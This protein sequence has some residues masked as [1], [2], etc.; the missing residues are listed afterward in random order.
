MSMGFDF[1]MIA[2]LLLSHCGVSVFG[3]RAFF[4]G[5]FQL[6]FFVTAASAVSCDFG[7]FLRR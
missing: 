3:C 7:V 1:N 2:P 4:S 5:R 6:F